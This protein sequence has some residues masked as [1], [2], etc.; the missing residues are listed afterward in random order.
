MPKPLPRR[1]SRGS[2]AGVPIPTDASPPDESRGDT[3]RSRGV[4][5]SVGGALG[6]GG[7]RTRRWDVMGDP[8]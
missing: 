7:V 3:N 2:A 1:E 5:G 8:T 6:G 4:Q